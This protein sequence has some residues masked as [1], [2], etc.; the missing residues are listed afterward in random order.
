M[1][2]G[3]EFSKFSLYATSQ[4]EVIILRLGYAAIHVNNAF[5]FLKFLLQEID[6]VDQS[7]SNAQ[8][9]VAA[10]KNKFGTTEKSKQPK[11]TRTR[12]AKESKWNLVVHCM[13][14]VIIINNT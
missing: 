6:L 12:V 3:F 2:L 5:N 7:R 1:P 9:F 14:S 4:L 10:L 11:M 8:S 13:L